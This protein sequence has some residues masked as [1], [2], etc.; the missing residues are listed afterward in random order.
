MKNSDCNFCNKILHIPL[1]YGE[2]KPRTRK[3]YKPQK[4]NLENYRTK[5]R[6]FLKR[7]DNKLLF[8][9]KRNVRR[10]NPRKNYDKT[11]RRFICN[12]PDHLSKTCSNKDKT[13]T[14]ANMKNK[15]ES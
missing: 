7:S 12:L 3:N 4:K 9:H 13:C 5:R 15:K 2:E 10:Y 14:L 6:Y 1:N 11:C 8:L